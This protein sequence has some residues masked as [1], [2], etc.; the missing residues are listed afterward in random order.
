MKIRLV[1]VVFIALCALPTLA[2]SPPTGPA[3]G[4]ASGDRLADLAVRLQALEQQ[5]KDRSELFHQLNQFFWLITAL[6]GVGSV[7]TFLALFRDSFSKRDRAQ[8]RNDVRF[9]QEIGKHTEEAAKAQIENLTHVSGLIKFVHDAF[10]LQAEQKTMLDNLRKEQEE[11]FKSQIALLKDA[12]DADKRR[13]EERNTDARSKYAAV[14]AAMST[15]ERIQALE[16]PTVPSFVLNIAENARLRMENIDRPLLKN[17]IAEQPTLHASLLQRMGVAAYYDSYQIQTALDLLREAEELF[18]AN[19]DDP[20]S[21]KARAYTQ[22]FL[23]II[24]KNWC[25]TGDTV[26]ANLTRAATRLRSAVAILSD[27]PDHFLTPVTLAEVLSYGPSDGWDEACKLLDDRIGLVK[28]KGSTT[29][30][31][32]QRAL[33]A[34]AL[35]LRGNIAFR[36][37]SAQEEMVQSYMEAAANDNPYGLLSVASVSRETKSAD[38]WREGLES[39]E[40]S[41]ALGKQ[42]V[43]QR[44]TAIAWAILA[45]DKLG[46]HERVASLSIDLSRSGADKTI[47]GLDPVYFSPLQKTVVRFRHLLK[48]LQGIKPVE[49][50]IARSGREG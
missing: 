24:E 43:T 6:A 38:L 25:Q 12:L 31:R 37:R 2:Q 28:Q 41:G 20:G 35:L 15:F 46:E 14:K 49:P 36:R 4:A 42:E 18:N 13:E 8:A 23:A 10:S 40:K 9:I 50:L 44:V 29:L 3:P 11:G 1:I 27:D 7:M 48:D 34:R 47:A 22:H 5:T 30:D 16:W 21:R 32:N 17:L 33:Y 39:L 26:N 45:C 19:S